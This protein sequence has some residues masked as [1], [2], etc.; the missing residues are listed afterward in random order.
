M[1][2]STSTRVALEIAAGVVAIAGVGT[3]GLWLALRKKPTAEELEGQRRD[4]LVKSGRIVDGMLLDVCE[5]DAEDGRKLTL[6]LFSYRIGGVD[7]ECS[8]DITNMAEVVDPK[9]IQLGLPCSVRYQ[10]GNPQNS[11]VVAEQW[12]G[13][14]EGIPILPEYKD[15]EP[16]DMSHLRPNQS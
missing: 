10:P 14:R 6:V 7:Y 15:T 2:L 16:N 12:T 3:V 4:S 8:Q 9:R 5:V 13:L 1:P 11:V